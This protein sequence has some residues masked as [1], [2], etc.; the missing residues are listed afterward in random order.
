MIYDKKY[1][2][3]YNIPFCKIRLFT[4]Y[5]QRTKT[6]MTRIHEMVMELGDMQTIKILNRKLK[7][8]RLEKLRWD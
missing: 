6:P 2:K 5:S 3:A 4:Y 1:C 7:D 8:L